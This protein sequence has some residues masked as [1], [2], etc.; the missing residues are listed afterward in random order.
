MGSGCYEGLPADAR[1]A[2]EDAESL[3]RRLERLVQALALGNELAADVLRSA[4]QSGESG[5]VGSDRLLLLSRRSEEY[6]Q[7]YRGFER[8]LSRHRG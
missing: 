5:E 4:A 8:Q 1:R 2:L 6:A 7:F 3:R